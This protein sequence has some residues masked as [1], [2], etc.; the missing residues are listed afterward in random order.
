MICA[1]INFISKTCF[2]G[3]GYIGASSVPVTIP[4]HPGAAGYRG[5]ISSLS[6]TSSPI[7]SVGTNF[8]PHLPGQQKQEQQLHDVSYSK[9]V[10]FCML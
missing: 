5:S 6:P 2:S 10:Y 8:L 1:N 3:T 4:S 9:R 7:G